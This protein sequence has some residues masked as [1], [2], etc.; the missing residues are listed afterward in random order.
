MVCWWA[1]VDSFF[2]ASSRCRSAHAR[3]YA[4]LISSLLEHTLLAPLVAPAGTR[5]SSSD[6]A[7]R[8]GNR[9]RRRRERSACSRKTSKVR[10]QELHVLLTVHSGVHVHATCNRPLMSGRSSFMSTSPCYEIR[11]TSTTDTH[12]CN[13][14]SGACRPPSTLLQRLTIASTQFCCWLLV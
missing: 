14:L 5:S 11:Q 10:V 4:H 3:T 13:V 7:S 9:R 2:A 1:L 8:V 6:C 12:R